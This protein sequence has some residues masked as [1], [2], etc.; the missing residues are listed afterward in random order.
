MYFILLQRWML[1]LQWVSQNVWVFFLLWG[2]SWNM[3]NE[4]FM[5]NTEDWLDEIKL[6]FSIGQSG[7]APK[8]TAAYYG[9][10]SSRGEYMDMSAIYPSRMQLNNLKWETSTE[11]NLGGD[12][13][14]SMAS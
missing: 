13:S 10:Y 9:A 8:G 7:N 12:F 3:Q 2:I 1:I 11:Y 14:F 5:K 4:P 6:R